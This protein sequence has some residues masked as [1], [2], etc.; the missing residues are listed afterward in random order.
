ML[1]DFLQSSFKRYKQDTDN[2]ATWLA[3]KAKQHGY[4]VD[5]ENASKSSSKSKRKK[6]KARKLAKEEG[7]HTGPSG[8]TTNSSAKPQYTVKI[9]DFISLAEFI[10]GYTNPVI[11]APNI[12]VEALNR[13]IELRAQHNDWSRQSRSGQDPESRVTADTTHSY[14][15]GILDRVREILKPRMPADITTDPPSYSVND[16]GTFESL[17]TEEQDEITNRFGMLDLEDPS[18]AF[19]DAPGSSS[20]PKV[21]APSEPSYESETDQSREEKYLAA[22]CL[23]QDIRNIRSFIRTLWMNY[24]D[25]QLSHVSVSI[26]TN[27]AICL[28]RDMEEDFARRFPGVSGFED[29]CWLFYPIQCLLR[30]E[31]PETKERYDDLLNFEVYDIAEDCLVS[32]YTTMSSLQ[33]IVEPGIMP[34]YK[35][36]HYGFRD[37]SK[38][39]DEKTPRGKF[40]DDQLILMEA[41]PDLVLLSMITSRSPLAEDELIRGV[42]DMLPGRPIPV[43]LVFAGRCFLDIQHVLEDAVGNG[44]AQLGRTA[45]AMKTSIKQN[46]EFHKSLR[47]DNWPKPNDFQFTETLGVID[48]WVMRDVIAERRTKVHYFPHMI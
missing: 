27:T 9:K 33:D 23:F 25:D 3:A 32:T 30:G 42:R 6:G 7:T 4:P 38:A 31:S 12:F 47:V 40:K 43:W 16:S 17:E 48:S 44:Y 10:A 5:I 39:W 2:V 18:Q 1:P 28:V 14:F 24:R 11:Q 22:H 21:E 29:I 15:L 19:L 8:M 45:H 46:M 36:G 26:A 35:T 13:A 37:R 20:K 34:I 41:F